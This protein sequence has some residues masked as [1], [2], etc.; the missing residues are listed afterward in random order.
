M[1]SAL[2]NM[3]TTNDVLKST[4]LA[5]IVHEE[6]ERNKRELYVSCAK[7]CGMW[8]LKRNADCEPMYTIINRWIDRNNDLLF[9][10]PCV[11]EFRDILV[12]CGF[13]QV[14]PT[15]ASDDTK[16]QYTKEELKSNIVLW[17]RK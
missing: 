2:Q 4:R 16:W 10:R 9:D 13:E 3:K 15:I 6:C 5:T 8:M 1:E 7:R 12:E 11:F 17:K 14:W